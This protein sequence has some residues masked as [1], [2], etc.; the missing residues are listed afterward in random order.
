MKASVE[1]IREE[2]GGDVRVAAAVFN[3]SG[4]FVRKP[5]LELTEGDLDGS[6]AGS[7]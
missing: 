6:Y 5:F 7:V 4:P 1:K 3:G 2:Y